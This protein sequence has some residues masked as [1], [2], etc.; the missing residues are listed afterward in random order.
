MLLPSGPDFRAVKITCSLV[1]SDV[2]STLGSPAP[3]L[4]LLMAATTP[5][6]TSLTTAPLM[7]LVNESVDLT[8]YV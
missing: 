6:T 7:V 1:L 3:L 2:T 8:V 4:E 5:A